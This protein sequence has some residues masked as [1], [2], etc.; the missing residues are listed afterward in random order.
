MAT[1]GKENEVSASIDHLHSRA[2]PWR[3]LAQ[4]E[5]SVSPLWRSQF[6]AADF[7]EMPLSAPSGKSG[8]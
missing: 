7:P 1:A 8:K 3:T 6:S 5:L 4:E 2:C